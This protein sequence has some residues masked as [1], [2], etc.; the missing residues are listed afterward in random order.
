MY[1][2]IEIK[3]AREHN[4]KNI[5]VQI[6]KNQ[7]VALTGPSGSGKSTFAFD[8]LQRECQ[9]QY[10]ES[11]GM[12][13][14][15][16]NNAQVDRIVGLSPSISISQGINNR[17]PR[18]T[19]GTYTEILTYLRLLYAKCG[20]RQ[21]PHCSQMI[22]PAF[23]SDTHHDL[24][25]S[26]TKST[27]CP[28]CQREIPTLTMAHFSFNKAEGFCKRCSGLGQVNEIDPMGIIDDSLTVGQGAV[29]M[30]QGMMAK[31]YEHVLQA[32]ARHY[33]FH[34]DVDQPIRNYNRLEKLVFFNGVSSKDFLALYPHI[35]PPK[36]VSD[37]YFEG[38][39]TYLKKKSA[40]NIQKGSTNK[41]I[42]ACFIRKTCPECKGTRLNH[43]ART[44]SLDQKSI[45]ELSTFTIDDLKAWV[46]KLPNHLEDQNKDVLAAITQDILRRIESI[47]RIGLGY[48]TLDRTIKSL[49]G[50]EAQRLRMA[51]LMDS[52]LTGVLYILDE[53]T[54][55]LHPKDTIKI[56]NALKKLRDIG[57]TILVIEH[58]MDFVA[59][60]DYVIDFGP[61]SGIQGGQ[62]VATGKPE[63]ISTFES[64]ATGKYLHKKTEISKGQNRESKK[65]LSIH[66]ARQHNLKNINVEIPL[67]R[68][69]TFTGVSGSGKSTLIFDVLAGFAYGQTDHVDKIT[70]LDQIDSIIQVNQ[71]R[72]GRSSR[73]T[74]ATYTDIFTPIRSLFAHLKSAKS[75][76]LK[77]SDFSFNVRGGRCEKCKGLGSIPL[78]MHFLDDIEVECPLC[79]GKRFNHKVMDVTYEGFTISEIL[80]KTVKQNLEIF[81]DH[82]EIYKR[83]NVLQEVGLDYLTLGQS[84]STLSGGECQ[85]IKLSKELGKSGKGHT[86]YL[87]DEPTSGL[88]PSDIKKL[89][90]LLKKL[91][92]QGNSIL[93]IEHSLA[94][95][96]QS[97]WIIDLGPGG[98]SEGGNLVAEGSPFEIMQNPHSHTGHFLRL[99]NH[100]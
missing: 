91:V 78:N 61:L 85:R 57:N 37:G 38:I 95:I 40:E 88:H 92:D 10:M 34:F 64:S 99:S 1:K 46:G 15:G 30:W 41:K 14:D 54:S 51:N 25:S 33:G 12:V 77:S 39:L 56:L 89:L 82:N 74:L 35:K 13:T 6:P 62:I 26:N 7:L 19:V 84:T 66:H 90:V 20:L 53:P 23:V 22:P 93:I 43:Q 87:L 2:F 58:D 69:V 50:G 47:T 18:S 9:R 73:S 29:Q 59:Q 55:G 49:S 97:D 70:G 79:H 67:N 3:G 71:Q 27:Q 21:C 94:V 52:G 86:L 32:A 75:H 4:L 24:D 100:A 76:G 60:C 17:N 80:E 98:G 5:S 31:H 65:T 11:M 42:E 81:K 45:V 36:K 44:V 63:E 48:L 68:L 72:I 83:L 28:H 96:S 8:I 16:M